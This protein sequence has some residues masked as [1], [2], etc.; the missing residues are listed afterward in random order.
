MCEFG[1][2]RANRYRR[3]ER[4]KS[5]RRRNALRWIGRRGSGM[6]RGRGEKEKGAVGRGMIIFSGVIADT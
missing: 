5:H 6:G 1:Q 2:Q 4:D 3:F